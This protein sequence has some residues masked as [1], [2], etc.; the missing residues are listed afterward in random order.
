M[1]AAFPT[2]GSLS[3][4]KAKEEDDEDGEDE[5]EEAEEEEEESKGSVVELLW[6]TLRHYLCFS[7][8]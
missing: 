1:F 7:T 2:F 6:I 8:L 5:D 4:R 3:W